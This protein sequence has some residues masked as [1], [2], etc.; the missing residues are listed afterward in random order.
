MR[1]DEHT[2]NRRTDIE[3]VLSQTTCPI[4]YEHHANCDLLFH[5]N[6]F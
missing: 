3:A 6:V 4:L 5:I 1:N 2:N